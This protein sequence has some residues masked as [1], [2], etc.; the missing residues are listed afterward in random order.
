MNLEQS[1]TS[2][3]EQFPGK[4]RLDLKR[5]EQLSEK[6]GKV[7]FTGFG[8]VIAIAIISFIYWI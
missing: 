4:E 1:A 3:L 8:I 6:F 2:L 7:A 5:E